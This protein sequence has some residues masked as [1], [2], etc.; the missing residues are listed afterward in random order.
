MKNLQETMIRVKLQS[1][2]ATYAHQKK[3]MSK[4]WLWCRNRLRNKTM[5]VQG[6]NAF[7][8]NRGYYSSTFT[9]IEPLNKDIK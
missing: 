9:C 3:L 6:E 5:R 2:D 4:V 1:G 7:Y 8:E